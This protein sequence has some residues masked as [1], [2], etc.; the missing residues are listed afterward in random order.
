MRRV[1]ELKTE[2]LLLKEAR[3][4]EKNAQIL[5]QHEHAALSKELTKEK[6]THSLFISHSAFS[7][8]SLSDH[9]NR[10]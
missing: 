5:L 7:R 8:D 3:K 2:L 4:E 6:V 1:E 9:L 10:D